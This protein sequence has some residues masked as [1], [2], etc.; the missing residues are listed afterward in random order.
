MPPPSQLHIATQAVQRLLKEEMY[1]GKELAQQQQRVKKLEEDAKTGVGNEDGNAEFVL[2]QEVRDMGV[3]AFDP[4]YF[5][6]PLVLL[7]HSVLMCTY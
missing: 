3:P 6:F 7:F 1:Y 2:R 5:C 4:S